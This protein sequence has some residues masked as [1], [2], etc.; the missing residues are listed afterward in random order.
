[1]KWKIWHILLIVTLLYPLIAF[2]EGTS[3]Q[4]ECY[5][6]FGYYLVVSGVEVLMVW[7]GYILG[8][9]DSEKE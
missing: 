3:W 9:R 5:R 2:F 6:D 4:G 8:K 7:C 1:M